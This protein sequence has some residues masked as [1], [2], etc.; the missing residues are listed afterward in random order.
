MRGSRQGVASALLA[1]LLLL[2]FLPGDAHAIP[3][4][5]RKY[6]VTCA[7]CH[8]PFPR[9]NAFGNM[10]AANGFQM[11]RGEPALDTTS[12]PCWVWGN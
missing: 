12:R 4:F 3:A 9:L 10:F 8:A 1:A 6:K 7:L 5:A 2:T 11:A